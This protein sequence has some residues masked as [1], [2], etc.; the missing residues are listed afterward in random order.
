MEELNARMNRPKRSVGR[1]CKPAKC[2]MC[3]DLSEAPLSLFPKP[4]TLLRMRCL[5]LPFGSCTEASLEVYGDAA[6]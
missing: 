2:Y 4:S 6:L 1:Q 5:A 3:D